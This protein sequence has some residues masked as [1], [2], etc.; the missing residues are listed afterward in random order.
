[1]NIEKAI[2]N[3]KEI[4]YR[5]EKTFNSQMY[6]NSLSKPKVNWLDIPI[7]TVISTILNYFTNLK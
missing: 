6:I 1:M 2:E 3:Y 5:F 4:G 7:Q